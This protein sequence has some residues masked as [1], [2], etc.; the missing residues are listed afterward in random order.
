MSTATSLS[1]VGTA[2][3]PAIGRRRPAALSLDCRERDIRI[4]V[5]CTATMSTSRP[6]HNHKWDSQASP[7][8]LQTETARP[9]SARWNSTFVGVNDA[10]EGTT[11]KRTVRLG[12]GEDFTIESLLANDSDPEDD[13]FRFN[14][15]AD[16]PAAA[17]RHWSWTGAGQA[18]ADFVHGSTSA[19]PTS[20]Y[21]LI[22]EHGAES[23]AEIR[24]QSLFRSTITPNARGTMMVSWTH[25]G[26]EPIIINPAS[27]ARQ[28]HGDPNGDPLSIIEPRTV[29]RSKA[30]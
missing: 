30:R 6:V 21:K 28:R 19:R 17:G 14:G 24:D 2:F 4:G 10:P 9:R 23:T 15:I 29:S 8:R 22:D 25:R 18:H 20:R 13:E 26:F 27:S 11:D 16:G 3:G 5:L 1:I 7:I 12:V